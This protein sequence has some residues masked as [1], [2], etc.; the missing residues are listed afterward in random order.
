MFSSLSTASTMFSGLVVVGMFFAFGSVTGTT[1]TITDMVIRKMMSK[2]SMTSTSGVVLIVVFSS[3]SADSGD[4]TFMAMV[5]TSR[6]TSGC[7]LSLGHKV[8]LQVA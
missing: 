2:T 6:L 5:L 4:A 7:L 1:F 8:G 3:A